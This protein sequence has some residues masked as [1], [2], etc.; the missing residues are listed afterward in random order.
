MRGMTVLTKDENGK[1]IKVF[2]GHRDLGKVVIFVEHFVK[3]SRNTGSVA[4]FHQKA[5]KTYGLKPRFPRDT[6]N[7]NAVHGVSE[8]DYIDAFRAG[9]Q[10]AFAA[11]C[12]EA[13]ML[14]SSYVAGNIEGRKQVTECLE[15]VASFYEH[16]LFTTQANYANRTY[17]L[18]K[19]KLRNG[20]SVSDGFLILVRNEQGKIVE[21][22]D[23]PI[24]LHAGTLISAFLFE[25]LC[26]R[27][28][29]KRHCMHDGLFTDAVQKYS[30]D[31]VYGERTRDLSSYKGFLAKF[32]IK[33]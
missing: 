12:D 21:I 13:V 29:A 1:V 8:I 33:V 9:S 2:N 18:Y 23:N 24:P 10:K 5:L 31:K 27:A 22:L 30:L 11:L 7:F 16:C 14:A 28:L 4:L 25:H 15:K 6:A 26:D 20:L 17:L 3:G 32:L 19:G